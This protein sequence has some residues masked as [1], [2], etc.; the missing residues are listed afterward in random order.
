[1]D[2]GGA[3]DKFDEANALYQDDDYRAALELLDALDAAYPENK[4]ILYA[5]AQ[6]CAK[7]G[8]YDTA[9]ALCQT[10]VERWDAPRA[11]QL[12][13]RLRNEEYMHDAAGDSETNELELDSWHSSVPIWIPWMRG[14]FRVRRW[15]L[16]AIAIVGTAAVALSAYFSRGDEAPV[17]LSAF[18]SGKG[19]APVSDFTA[20]NAE[21]QA[22]LDELA[23]KRAEAARQLAEEEQ[24]RI[25]KEDGPSTEPGQVISEEVWARTAVNGLP[26]WKPGIYYR[27]PCPD[28]FVEIQVGKV[29]PRSIDVYIPM[30]YQ[31]R[32]SDLFPVVVMC[33]PVMYRGFRGLENWAELN[34]VLLVVV[35]TSCNRFYGDNWKAQDAALTTI[36]NSMRVDTTMGFAIGMS[37]GAATA[38]EMICRY[39]NNFVGV[40][41]MGMSRSHND[42]WIPQHVRVGYIMGRTD[43]NVPGLEWTIPRLKARG[44]QMRREVVA[45]GHVVGPLPVREKMLSWML[46]DARRERGQLNVQ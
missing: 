5:R 10:C 27:V 22:K 13:D 37:G 4:N 36:A 38:W 32:P 28:A 29:V 33:W 44:N 15:A 1:M 25:E 24:R 16:V 3:L 41:M 7:L 6:C 19:E 42:C 31:E 9:V 17:A 35:N 20:A 40:V 8:K 21:F 26:Q 45:G 18:I 14:M 39:P 11:K 23:R 30:A 2:K 43:H 34:D 46:D 12:L